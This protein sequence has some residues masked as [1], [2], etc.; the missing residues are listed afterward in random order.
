MRDADTVTGADDRFAPTREAALLRIA[1]IRPSD[2][3]RSRNALDGAVTRLSP[4]LTHGFISLPA[5]HAAITAR[6]AIDAQHKLVYEFGW[7]EY[8]HHVWSHRGD[9]IFDSLHEGLL[10]GD[11][12]AS[13]L[14]DDIREAR[15]GV[16]VI[17]RAVRQL[18]ATGYLHN[19]VRMWLASY[20][21]HLRKVHWR[22][23]A[24]WLYAHLL[25]GDLASNHLSWQWIAATASHK[26]Y[27]FNA[28]NV[29]KYAPSEWHSPRS[30][31]DT[32]Y[33]ALDVIARQPKAVSWHP[34]PDGTG[35]P[36]LLSEPPETL[37]FS[38][39][40]AAAIAGRD[41]W[42]VHPWSLDEPPPGLPPDC[43]MVALAIANWHARWPW[44]ERRWQFVG[45]R[46]RVLADVRWFADIAT[47]RA[48]LAGA[49]SVHAIDDPHCAQALR[50]LRD[51]M[52]LQP[53]AGLF[54]S[55]A[56][57]CDSFSQWWRLVQRR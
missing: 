23:G 52:Q 18:Y 53:V 1:A 19:H 50:R 46:Q 30:V 32:S 6:H 16:P 25:D 15:T 41:V 21:V 57:C 24:D 40:D 54:P 51:D 33:E 22:T 11:A 20:V 34:L 42:L 31:I 55:V 2:Y 7:R 28:E 14:P 38:A 26:P 10:P 27:L 43:V 9:G 37:G 47:L 4:Y 49:R 17:D 12:Y 29:A 48:A 3:A 35:E 45:T 13:A 56:R 44:S 5:V 39:P 36:L 8:W